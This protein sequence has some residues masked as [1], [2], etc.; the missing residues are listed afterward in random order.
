MPATSHSTPAKHR[1]DG[2][3]PV[4]LHVPTT[5]RKL[6]ARAR[7]ATL[8]RL[9][10]MA[11][12]LS[13]VLTGISPPEFAKD[14]QGTPRPDNGIHWSVSHKPECVAGVVA[15]APVGIDIE[16]I[17]A[18]SE[19]LYRRIATA[20]EW[21]LGRNPLSPR[22]FYRVWTAKEAVLKAEGIGLRGLSRCRVTAMPAG[23]PM[24]LAFDRHA[25]TV[26][27]HDLPV[28]VVAITRLSAPIHW[29][30]DPGWPPRR[31]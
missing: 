19:A 18:P 9:A 27:H 6:P 30:I 22:Q 26:V 17:G 12:R 10:R 1:L 28:H 7:V 29:Q 5:V 3:Y 31:K 8:S 16:H 13:A 23:G 25:W 20:E 2:L 14:D 4:V 24:R 21:R 11:A 15:A